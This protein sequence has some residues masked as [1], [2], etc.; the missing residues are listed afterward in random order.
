MN[1]PKHYHQL[2]ETALVRFTDLCQDDLDH[3]LYTC[4]GIR[5]NK[6]VGAQMVF[7]RDEPAGAVPMP[8]NDD[9]IRIADE[10]F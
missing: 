3:A 6:P 4:G 1:A 5:E 8:A 10:A 2:P 7:R 9:Y